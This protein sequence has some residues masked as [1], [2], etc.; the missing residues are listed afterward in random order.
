MLLQRCLT[1]VHQDAFQVSI[2][3]INSKD[4]LKQ[5]RYLACSLKQEV[6][7]RL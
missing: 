1:E 4:F 5:L 2:Y 7:N 3:T 6:A